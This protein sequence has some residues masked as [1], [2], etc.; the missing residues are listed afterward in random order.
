MEGSPAR[1]QKL[2]P[3]AALLI[4]LT[5]AETQSDF[6][7]RFVNGLS[8]HIK[9]GKV[10][11]ILKSRESNELDFGN[12]V[13]PQ[14]APSISESWLKSHLERHPELQRKLQQGEMVGITYAEG[15]AAP[16][17]VITPRRNVLLLPNIVDAE[18]VGVIGLVLPMEDLQQSEDEVELVRQFSHYV[19]PT[20]ARLRELEQLRAEHQANESLQAILEM[21]SHLQSN[22]SHE[23]RT[24]LAAVRGYTRMILDGRTG[25]ISQTQRDYLNIVTEN[26]NRLI[27]LVNWMGHVLQYGAQQLQLGSTDLSD[28]LA[29]CLKSHEESIREKSIDCKQQIGTGS[30]LTICDR[31]KIEFVIKILLENAIRST[32]EKGTILVELYRGRQKEITVKITDSGGGIPPEELN[33]TFERYYGSLLPVKNPTELGVAGVHDIIGLHGGRLFVSNRSEGSTYLFTLPA[34]R[35][36]VE[37]KSSDEQTINSGRRRR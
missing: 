9:R 11:L 13:F 7:D 32:D 6:A 31:Y 16:L 1:G 8:S 12:P 36:N 21:Q 20:L 19:S 24:P 33:K 25:E 30:F 2:D 14:D 23:L 10:L 17:S 22:V 3:L 26:A 27:Q 4:Q 28:I 29:L 15:S 34:V 5:A 37:E 18:L 35:Q